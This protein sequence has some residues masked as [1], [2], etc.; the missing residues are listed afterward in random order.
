MRL[1]SPPGSRTVLGLTPLV[2][3]YFLVFTYLPANA[4]LAEQDHVKFC[5]FDAT[6]RPGKRLRTPILL[7]FRLK[8]L[9]AMHS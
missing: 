8:D 2:F 5:D 1:D 4:M 6:I 7:S 3:T 9:L